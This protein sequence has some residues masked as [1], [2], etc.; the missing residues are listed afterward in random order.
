MRRPSAIRLGISL[1]LPWE[2]HSIVSSKNSSNNFFGNLENPSTWFLIDPSAISLGI[3][4]EISVESVAVVSSGIILAI[5]IRIY[6]YFFF[7]K[8]QGKLLWTFSD[9]F[10][11][12]SS[13]FQWT[14]L[15]KIF[16]ILIRQLIFQILSVIFL[17]E[18]TK[19]KCTERNVEYLTWL[20]V[21]FQKMV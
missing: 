5:L 16:R 12:N 15:K 18:F 14:F 20:H 4:A 10:S 3:L 1:V 6:L 13:F 2:N 11:E 19:K 21:K 17:W 9:T 7:R 8:R